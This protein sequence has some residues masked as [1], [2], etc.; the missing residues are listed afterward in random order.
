MVTPSC[1]TRMSNKVLIFM[2]NKSRLGENLFLKDYLN[3]HLIL[4]EEY[5]GK[6]VKEKVPF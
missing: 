6:A 1:K 5:E 4:K 2:S 3:K